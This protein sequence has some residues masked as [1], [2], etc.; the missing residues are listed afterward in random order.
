MTTWVGEKSYLV[1]SAEGTWGTKSGSPVYVYHPVN[2]YTP[3]MRWEKK[4]ARPFAG[5]MQPKN[6]QKTRGKVSGQIATSLYGWKPGSGITTSLAEYIMA[7]CLG[8]NDQD[9]VSK[10]CEWAR[11]PNVSNKRHLGMR[12]TGW[13]L[14]GSGDA[15]NLSIDVTGKDEVGQD[16]FTTAQSV[17]NDQEG[18]LEM[19]FPGS[20]LTLGGTS[21]GFR[22]FELAVKYA[23]AEEYNASTRL[24]ILRSS[25]VE[26]ATF[27]CQTE[28]VDDGWQDYNRD[29]AELETEVVLAIQGL[30]NGTG[31]GG[32][33]YTVGTFT[34]PRAQLIDPGEDDSRQIPY[35]ELSFN[36]LKPDTSSDLLS[37]AWSEV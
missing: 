32:T 26:S 21:Y 34:L 30:H 10:T 19:I 1:M 24:S 12:V 5:V 2:S 28:N 8:L 13:T 16:T 33:D 35:N 36:L 37:L 7:W 31:T 14:S 9:R 18:V 22:S 27:K 11:G 3:K 20:T 17:P 29:S 15:V 4:M 25:G 6:G 23:M